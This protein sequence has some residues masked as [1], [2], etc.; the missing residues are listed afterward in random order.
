MVAVEDMA[1]A[2]IEREN[3]TLRVLA[4]ELLREHPRL[5]DLPRPQ[6]DDPRLLSVAAALVELFAMRRHQDPPEWTE[7]IGPLTEPFF[8]L[9]AA[10]SMRRLRALCETQSPEPLRRR[11]L[12]APPNF[13]EFA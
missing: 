13:L 9:N 4:Q 11:R 1:K 7:A 5:S 2:A 12:Y 6:T 10:T 8:L 3:L